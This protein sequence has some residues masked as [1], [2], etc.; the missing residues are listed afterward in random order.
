MAELIRGRVSPYTFLGRFQKQQTQQTDSTDTTIALR[1]NQLAL[2]N[3]NSSLVRITEQINI[4]SASLQGVSNQIKETSS[5][6]NVRDQQ[7]QRQEKALAERQIREGK[8]S[9]IETKLQAALTKPLQIVGAKAQG[10]LFSLG[11]FFN[12]LLGG[13]LLNRILDAASELSEDGKLSLKNLGDKIGKDLAI[14]GGI[15]GLLNGGFITLLSSSLRLGLLLGRIGINGLLLAPIRL[16]FN[17]AQNSLRGLAT[18][19]RGLPVIPSTGSGNNAGGG[20]QNRRSSGSNQQQGS[21][22]RSGGGFPVGGSLLMTAFN[23]FGLNQSL[24]QAGSG[25]LAGGLLAAL[26]PPQLRL[27]MFLTGSFLGPEIYQSNRQQIESMIP[28]L[29]MNKDQ[30]IDM[31]SGRTPDLRPPTQG[32]NVTIIES[33]GNGQTQQTNAPSSTPQT[34]AIPLLPSTNTDNNFFLLYSKIQYNVVG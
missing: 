27:A 1:Q 20:N 34:T 13:F 12:I 3:V 23:F 21:R 29:G 28:A 25:P 16:A 9:L 30:F 19:I 2:S 14:V 11:R 8:E 22:N 10:S 26:A 24:G 15:F 17:I 18:R 33:G 31:M 32:G 7:K 4:L 6:E 5:L